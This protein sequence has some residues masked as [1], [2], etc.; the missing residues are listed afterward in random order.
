MA[1]ACCAVG[2]GAGWGACGAGRAVCG[3]GLAFWEAPVAAVPLPAG[4]VPAVWA[5]GPG[6]IGPVPLAPGRTASRSARR[7]ASYCARR[8]G[9]PRTRYAW[10]TCV[11]IFWPSALSLTT[12][13]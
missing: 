5:A 12:S 10:L 9:S 7:V 2:C 4:V 13:G 11:K 6:A 3:A 8:S 1:C